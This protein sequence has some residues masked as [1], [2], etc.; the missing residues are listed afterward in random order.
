MKVKQLSITAALLVCAAVNAQTI[1]P[2]DFS[3]TLH[4]T[5]S[6][7]REHC[8]TSSRLVVKKIVQRGRNI[9]F[10]FG[11][12]LEAFPLR[13]GDI[14]WLRSCL[15]DNLP[16][17]YSKCKVAG[18]YYD[19]KSKP[20]SLIVSAPGNSGRASWSRYKVQDKRGPGLADRGIKAP[21]GLEGRHIALWQS[22]G[23]YYE[24]TKGEWVWQRPCIFQIVE[25]LSTQ[26]YV[27]PFLTPMLENAGANVL[28]PRERDPHE[29]EIIIDN[30][31]CENTSGRIHGKMTVPPVWQRAEGGFADKYPS[32]KGEENPFTM[33]T[34]LQC[35]AVTKKSPSK[36][37]SWSAEIPQRGEYAVYVAYKS[38]PSSC[39]CA[40]YTIHT[41]GADM[42]VTVNQQM[43][44]GS[45]VYLGSY[46]FA[47]GEGRLVSL[48]NLASKGGTISA[49]A[50]K[51]GGGMGN[52]ARGGNG[53][54]KTPADSSSFT[55]SGM[56][57]FTEG[58]RY[59]MQ[60]SGIP[61]KV[62]S[63]NEGVHDYRDDLMSRGM[64]TKYLSGG[65]WVNP[66]E[67]G[68]NIPVDLS[69]GFHSDAGIRPDDSIIG[70]LAIYTLKCDGKT[71]LPSGDS[72]NSCRELTDFVQTS[73][74]DD[75]RAQWDTEWNRRQLWNRS[76]SESRTTGV[77]AV[78]LELLSHQNFEDMKY[79]NDPYFRFT[80]SRS[81]YKA[82]LKFLSMHY[83]CPYVVQPLPVQAFSASLSSSGD[84]AYANLRWQGQNDPLEP[85][86]VPASYIVYTRIDDGGWDAGLK[87]NQNNI[88]LPIEKGHI[89]SYKVV[90][91]NEGGISFPSEILSVGTP[92][93]SQG[94]VLVV[95]NFTR[96]SGGTWFD[97]PSYAG[98]DNS[99]D[100]GVPY[101]QDWTFI[102]EQYDFN[103]KTQAAIEGKDGG[104]GSS[105]D[106]YAS[107][108]IGGNNFDYPYVH[109]RAILDA[110]YAFQSCAV[111]ALCQNPSLADGCMAA[112]IIC[113]KQC[114]VRTSNRSPL[115]GE[116]F[117][118]DL[119]QALCRITAKGCNILI[120]GSYIATDVFGSVFPIDYPSGSRTQVQDF[121][122]NTL[123]YTL[124]RSAASSCG[125]VTA[126]DG[127]EDFEFQTK[128]CTE[129]YCVESPDA[130]ISYNRNTEIFLNYKGSHLP[131]AIRTDLG[132]YKVAA[133]GFPIEIVTSAQGRDKIMKETLEWFGK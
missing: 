93:Q 59:F 38:T 96:I 76:Y 105:Y 51:I 17:K 63:Q 24:N 54:S 125:V 19:K 49:D 48:S 79:G 28:L 65:S 104:Y 66:K 35:Q 75:I 128:P 5:D 4:T 80:V 34:S 1:S 56:P 40:R 87:V 118:Q 92:E 132:N 10:Y 124:K 84:G 109:G 116:I 114:T 78:L 46:E 107:T 71:K 123:G 89:Y 106:D 77:P 88:T 39:N 112:D 23:R 122:R 83:G 26:G 57:R 3:Q 8:G 61:S 64:W 129:S 103:R 27:V 81:C 13:E 69:F 20:E 36:D 70:T 15:S 91:A 94:K 67:D 97:T 127:S 120:S 45:W 55:V 44:G 85:T 32:Y 43:G 62:W 41:A 14:S 99:S 18:I 31:P 12:S 21:K 95:N 82:I 108:V 98:F 72:R 52:I 110:G 73:V 102:G 30:D 16:D 111:L 133:F 58:A 113:G 9:D 11:A 50:V 119:R 101:I 74:V 90:A 100:S 117:S 7:M 53:S 37:I 42:I 60:W 130:I 131:A 126:T 6:L 29:C 121:V 22:H 33:G 115:R 86:A 25:D 68:L 2:A 47:K